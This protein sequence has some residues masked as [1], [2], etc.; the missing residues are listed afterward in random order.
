MGI[1][2]LTLVGS[3]SDFSDWFIGWLLYDLEYIMERKE[4]PDLILSP[5]YQKLCETVAETYN[6]CI[7]NHL[8]YVILINVTMI[9]SKTGQWVV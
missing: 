6:S 9:L 8:S 3:Y 7:I 5:Q 1:K 2:C 4:N